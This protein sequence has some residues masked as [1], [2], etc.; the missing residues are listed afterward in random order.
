MQRLNQANLATLSANI[1]APKYVPVTVS[2]GIVHFGVG[3]FHRA[4]QAIYCDALLNKGELKWGITGVS[5]RSPDMRDHLAPQDYLYTQATLGEQTQYQVVGALQDILVAPENPQAVIA[6]VANDT[7]Q[8]ITMTITEKG[9]DLANG[10]LNVSASGVAHDLADLS[11]PRTIYGYIA[12]GLIERCAQQGT[13]LNVLCCDNM[14]A[15]GEFVKAGVMVMLAQHR[16]QTVAWVEANVAFASS[17]VDRVTPATNEQLKYNV[18]QELGL[19]D[20]APVAAEPFTQ[21]IIEDN[22]AGERPPFDRVGALFVDDIT[23]FEKVK[24]RFLNA[25]HSMLAAM[26]YLAGDQYVHEA[27]RR[28]SMASFAEQ[29][30]KLNV[31]PVTHVPSGMSGTT[32]IDEVLARFR[33]HHLPYA[34]LQVGTDSS[35]KIQQRWFPAI[36]DALRVGSASD[37]MAFAV[38]TWASFIRKA[39]EQND[40]NDPLS[41]AFAQSSATTNTDTTDFATRMHGYLR[42][43]GAERFDFYHNQAFMDRVTQCHISIERLGVE[44]ALSANQIL[45]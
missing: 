6:A 19:V 25:S 7:T 17:M 43:A 37:Y 33:N 15:G 20:A 22:F 10:E 9:Y 29:A 14:H 21:W 8:L 30:L 44:Q 34:V 41:D 23:P 36:D 24:L 35:Q 31:L 16:P 12:A 39:L 3:N 13:K 26:G 1:I 27:L 28:A 5:M 32:Y 11:Q 42:L 38:A 2:S 18:A 45:C 40:L 4:H